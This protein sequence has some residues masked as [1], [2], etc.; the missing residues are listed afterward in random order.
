MSETEAIPAST[1]NSIRHSDLRLRTF[2]LIWLAV[3]ALFSAL[4]LAFIF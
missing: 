2:L 1:G 4:T 3:A